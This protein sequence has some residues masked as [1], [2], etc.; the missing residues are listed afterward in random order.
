MVGTVKEE[1]KCASF[2]SRKRYKTD[3]VYLRRQAMDLFLPVEIRGRGD[4]VNGRY[5]MAINM[6]SLNVIALLV[7]LF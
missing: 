1:K 2:V 4:I 6:P 7:L 3:G 5:I